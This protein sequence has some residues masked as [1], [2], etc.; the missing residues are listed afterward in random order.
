MESKIVRIPAVTH[1]KI[2]PNTYNN[3][4]GLI[5]LK[6]GIILKKISI[7]CLKFLFFFSD[8][9]PSNFL[10]AYFPNFYVSSSVAVCQRNIGRLQNN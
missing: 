3:I 1:L 4:S 2:S 10:V 6:G 5:V 9:I 7:P 8:P